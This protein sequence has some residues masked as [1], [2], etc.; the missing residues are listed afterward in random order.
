MFLLLASLAS[1]DSI[2]LDTGATIEGDLARYEYGGDCQLSV[3]EGDLSGVILIVPCHRVQSFVR[4][5]MRAPSPIGLDA[6]RARGATEGVGPI[7]A[8]A[9][10]GPRA[11]VLPAAGIEEVPLAPRDASRAFV[12]P[13]APD[14]EDRAF[15]VPAEPNEPPPFY[16]E[17]LFTANPIAPIVPA[18]PPAP[19]ASYTPPSD[20]PRL[21]PRMD[22]VDPRADAP[23][24]TTTRSVR[25]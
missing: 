23:A 10:E 11:E 16:D 14:D 19:S 24:P 18:P 25:F 7:D 4:T 3:T 6:E 15:V 17:P 9:F 12:E 5:S 20:G 1:A 2:T 13:D 8:K 22:D 21:A